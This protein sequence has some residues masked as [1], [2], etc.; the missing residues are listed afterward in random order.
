MYFWYILHVIG[1]LLGFTTLSGHAFYYV[2]GGIA[3]FNEP[4]IIIFNGFMLVGLP[5]FV[6]SFLN[7][8]RR[9]A[10]LIL[11]LFAA[12]GALFCLLYFVINYRTMISLMLLLESILT[13]LLFGVSVLS[14][15]DKK[16][17]AGLMV[18]AYFIFLIGTCSVLARYAGWLPTVFLTIHG[19]GR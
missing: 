5:L 2:W 8:T 18:L 11:N 15:R 9:W 13:L 10:K 12:T 19:Q 1:A 3:G 17:S 16:T 7:I 6:K 14:W 4:A